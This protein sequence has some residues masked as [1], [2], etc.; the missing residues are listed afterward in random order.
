MDLYLAIHYLYQSQWFK[1]KIKN[2]YYWIFEK[3]TP[4]ELLQAFVYYNF[5]LPDFK[6]AHLVFLI[7]LK[8]ISAKIDKIENLNP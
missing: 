2:T 7:I 6:S 3:A 8:H 1:C 5:Q 4:T